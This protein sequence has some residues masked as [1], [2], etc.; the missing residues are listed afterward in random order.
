V[1]YASYIVGELEIQCCSF[2]RTT[3][4]SMF[5]HHKIGYELSWFEE[6]NTTAVPSASHMPT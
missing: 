1:E 6:L 3:P 5:S 4:G 2:R